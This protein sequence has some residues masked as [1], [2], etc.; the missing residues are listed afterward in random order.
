MFINDVCALHGTDGNNRSYTL[1]DFV[2]YWDSNDNMGFFQLDI[3]GG[4]ESVLFKEYN[5]W[6]T[7]AEQNIYESNIDGTVYCEAD[8]LARRW[9]MP[10]D[11]I[12]ESSDYY[13]RVYQ[14][15]IEDRFG[16]T[17]TAPW[18]RMTS[19]MTAAEKAW[20]IFWYGILG[21]DP[22]DGSQSE[23]SGW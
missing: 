4:N 5:C 19:P 11:K 13:H 17:C 7:T 8:G 1:P 10:D 6:I 18:I 23:H 14:I 15:M 3:I 12:D 9:R 16:D 2:Q 22:G 21:L 20:N